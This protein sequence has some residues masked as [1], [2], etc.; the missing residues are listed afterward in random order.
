MRTLL[1]LLAFSLS[2]CSWYRMRVVPRE[3]V[4]DLESSVAEQ[5]R[6]PEDQVESR[7][8][9]L[10]TR[11]VD[12]CGHQ[13]VYAYDMMREEWVLASVEKR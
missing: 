8:L 4:D 9:T 10:L 1:L 12:A 6:C 7:P 11:V 3:D 5:L 2:A 13:R